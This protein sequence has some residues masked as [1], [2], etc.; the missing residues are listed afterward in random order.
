MV[1]YIHPELVAAK[2]SRMYREGPKNVPA[3]VNITRVY[4]LTS[5]TV[6]WSFI[7]ASVVTL[8]TAVA[9][10][11]LGARPVVLRGI[12]VALLVD[13]VA[14]WLLLQDFR[15]YSFRGRR[16]DRAE[17]AAAPPAEKVLRPVPTALTRPDDI[18][19]A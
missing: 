9:W 5:G 2:E 18:G 1:A 14:G 12:A 19:A 8:V 11:A 15:A 6:V 10:V 7:V 16:G 17:P 13:L 4:Y 3:P